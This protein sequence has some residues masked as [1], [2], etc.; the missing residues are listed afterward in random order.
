VP[1]PPTAN[2]AP[3]SHANP[4]VEELR[5]ELHS[6]RLARI[7]FGQA[8]TSAGRSVATSFTGPLMER[9]L[10]A[11]PSTIGLILGI[12]GLAGV[13][14]PPLVGAWS[15]ATR[16]QWGRRTPFIVVFSAIAALG[17]A[18]AGFA[19]TIPV[20]AVA[21]VLTFVGIV[22]SQ[23]PYQ[24]LVPDLLPKDRLERG[25]AVSSLVAAIGGGMGFAL[26]GGLFDLAPAAPFLACAA[27]IVVTLAW[28]LSGFREG[29]TPPAPHSGAELEGA[30]RGGLKWLAGNHS[31]LAF[32]GA[33]VV[34]WI[35]L[36]AFPPF[37]ILY[38]QNVL[39]LSP[40][41]GTG[42]LLSVGLVALALA[43]QIGRTRLD[44]ASRHRALVGGLL[45]I[46]AGLLIAY[47]SGS[48]LVPALL[49]LSL[50]ALGSSVFQVVPFAVAVELA[51]PDRVGA[52]SGISTMSK[53]VGIALAPPI[54]GAAIELAGQDYRAVL[55]VMAAAC[56]LSLLP[57]S[58][59]RHRPGR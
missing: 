40:L 46:A 33:Q 14:V 41:A 28:A 6:A 38:V 34:W 3:E 32:L 26:G 29:L 51:P 19:P 35:G 10:G 1:V 18:L 16:S 49:G 15:D 23:T 48:A 55:L 47:L 12:A 5:E 2:E 59:V 54:A 22:G 20:L 45:V 50:F 31:F 30:P 42:I 11:A 25:Y 53:A 56:L 21:V 58:L 17:L 8:G 57:F 9:T 52:Y 39:G 27:L 44:P 24:V 43:F 37:A 4:L 36:G 7:L 13:I